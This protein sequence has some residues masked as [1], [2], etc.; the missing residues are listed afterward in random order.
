MNISHLVLRPS[1]SGNAGSCLPRFSTMPFI[2]CNQNEVCNYASR[3]DKS[4][5]LATNRALPM[6]PVSGQD[7][8]PFISRCSVCETRSTVVAL[9][10]QDVS[11]PFC[12]RNW[13]TLWEGYSFAMVIL[14][15]KFTVFM[16]KFHNN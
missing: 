8:L 15:S 4:Y 12:P 6:M 3:N 16:L 14:S 1:R 10:S 9:H 13:D 2:F 7:I 11:V 5:W